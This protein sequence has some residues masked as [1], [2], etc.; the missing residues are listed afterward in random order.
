MAR[1]LGRCLRGAGVLLLLAGALSIAGGCTGLPAGVDPVDGFEAERFTGQWYSIKRLDHR[2][3]RGLTDVSAEYWIREDGRL[4]VRNR[5][6]DPSDEQWQEIEG[7][8]RFQGEPDVASLTVTFTW[9]IRGGYHVI[10][11]DKDAYEWAM[12]SG[13]TRGYLWILSR[14]PE[15]DEQILEELVGR[16]EA[17]GFDVEEFQ[18]VEHGTAP[19]G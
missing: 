12:V 9:P 19:S 10:A 11:L 16:A 14:E 3:E 4:G 8:A 7:T 5:G 2:F 17:L 18:R 13:P 15:L 6:Y 1:V